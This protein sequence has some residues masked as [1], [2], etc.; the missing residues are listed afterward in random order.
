MV[1][2]NNAFDLYRILCAVSLGET[3]MNFA[4]GH[5][6]FLSTEYQR[7][8]QHNLPPLYTYN[9]GQN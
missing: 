9:L 6:S 2:L 8:L 3:S 5:T 1:A 4:V 7:I